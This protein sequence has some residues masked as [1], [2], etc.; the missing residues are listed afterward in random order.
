MRWQT[1]S[2]LWL[3]SCIVMCVLKQN[4]IGFHFV[5]SI[6]YKCLCPVNE[7]PRNQ[8][9]PSFTFCA[10]SCHKVSEN[11]NK[12]EPVQNNTLKSES[13][14][15]CIAR[16]VKTYLDIW[17]NDKDTCTHWLTFDKNQRLTQC[18]KKRKKNTGY[19]FFW[20]V[21]FIKITLKQFACKIL[22]FVSHLKLRF[23]KHL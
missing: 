19:S 17:K 14:S 2:S 23:R 15:H 16:Y 11:R 3:W 22:L 4:S 21:Q 8:E 6:N 12:M 20:C 9:I 10:W 5:Y 13:E 1:G 7:L 18:I